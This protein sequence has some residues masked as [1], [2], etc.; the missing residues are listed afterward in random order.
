MDMQK[1]RVTCTLTFG[2]IYGQIIVWL[3]VIFLSLATALGLM[4]ASRPIYALA[5]VGLILVLSLPFLLF[6]FVTTL[7]NHIE[8]TSIDPATQARPQ[9]NRAKNLSNPAQ[10]AG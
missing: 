10:A 3:V 9:A 4:G 6:A 7:L 2:D 5:T 8:F 1:Y